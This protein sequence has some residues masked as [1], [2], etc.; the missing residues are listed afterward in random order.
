M[1][2]VTGVVRWV[3][4]CVE[5]YAAGVTVRCPVGC[6]VVRTAGGGGGHPACA[7]RRRDECPVSSTRRGGKRGARRA[8][9]L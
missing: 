2:L 4:D 3:R 1:L 7:G 5:A 9:F 8:H 6:G